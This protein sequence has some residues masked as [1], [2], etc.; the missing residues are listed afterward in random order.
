M[1]DTNKGGDIVVLEDPYI[2]RRLNPGWKIYDGWEIFKN[3]K[4]FRSKKTIKRLED[5]KVNDYFIFRWTSDCYKHAQVISKN[6]NTAYAKMCNTKT[7]I[8]LCF[9]QDDRKCWTTN[10]FISINFKAKVRININTKE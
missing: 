3:R 6:K 4:D 8:S 10:G 9:S 5:L 7:Y 2:T 1:N